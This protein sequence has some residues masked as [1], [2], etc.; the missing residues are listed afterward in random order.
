MFIY[1]VYGKYPCS[2]ISLNNSL[3]TSLSSLIKVKTL[4]GTTNV[5]GNLDLQTESS[6]KVI[7]AICRTDNYI[8]CEVH[9]NAAKTQWYAYLH[10]YDAIG[11]EAN[12]TNTV[13]IYYIE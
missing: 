10:K 9:L 5:S 8:V 12:K 4:T 6:V 7:S 2:L 1:F 11:A 13:D 3:Q